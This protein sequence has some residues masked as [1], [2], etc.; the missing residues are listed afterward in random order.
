MNLVVIP[1]HDWKKCEHEG[2]RTRDAHFMEEFGRHPLVDKMLVINRPT[3]LAETLLLRRPWKVARGTPISA[4]KTSRISQVGDKIYTCDIHLGDLIRPL[5]LKR[6]WVPLAY[7][8]PI[9]AKTV[10]AAL[11]LLGM[12]EDYSL[13][14]SAPLYVPLAKQLAPKTLVLD[15]QDNLLKH[16]LYRDT[17]HLDL[18]YRYCQDSADII[19]ANSLESARWLGENRSQVYYIANGVDVHTMDAN[20]TYPI[21]ADLIPLKKKPVVG[22]AGKMQEMVDVQL[23]EKLVKNLPEVNFVF[24]G[25]ILRPQWV[26]PL[27]Q[28]PN[29]YH[30]GDKNYN[31]LPAYL[32][33]FDICTIP[34][35]VQRQHGGDPI[36]FYEYLAMG[37]PIV[38][39]N[40]G[41]VS[42]FADYPQV[43]IAQTH[44][45]FLDG[46]IAYLDKL[47]KGETIEKRPV[48]PQHTWTYKVN[49]ILEQIQQVSLEKSAEARISESFRASF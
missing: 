49:T 22:Y 15:A 18:Y 38:T 5:R 6:K 42:E 24:I 45:E 37:K 9:V 44:D 4:T 27:W 47:A 25:Q 31:D 10:E 36:K 8:Q 32:A 20:R 1:F 14:M 11:E 26:K 46:I 30:L 21:P 39:T 3:S 13:F 28:Y 23:V 34:Y 2:F 16:S 43:A 33:A 17:P 29:V 12:H 19:F 48:P 35:S 41:G 7:E 40:I